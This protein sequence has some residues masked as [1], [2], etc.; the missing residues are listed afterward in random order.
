MPKATQIAVIGH[1]NPPKP[2]LDLALQLGQAIAHSGATLVCGGLQGV[3]S[4]AAQGAY[5]AGGMTVGILPSYEPQHANP[6]IQLVIPTGLGHAR[7]VLVVASGDVVIALPGS[8]G[9]RSEIAL[10]LKLGKT[11]IGLGDWTDEEDV[12]SAQTATQAVQLA[13]QSLSGQGD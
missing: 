12:V 6:Y 4:A 13:I 10:A 2:V 11:V 1:G 3:M 7:N 5:E 8:H 9:T